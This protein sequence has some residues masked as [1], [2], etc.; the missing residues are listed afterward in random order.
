MQYLVNSARHPP[1]RVTLQNF[2]RLDNILGLAGL[3]LQVNQFGS[4]DFD[5]ILSKRLPDDILQFRD[6]FKAINHATPFGA[7]GPVFDQ[8]EQLGVRFDCAVRFD[9]HTVSVSNQRFA[10]LAD[11]LTQRFSARETYPLGR[12]SADFVD[13]LVKTHIR[14]RIEFRIAEKA[15]KI[16]LC[17]AD[18]RRRL[19]YAQAFTLDRVE[20]LVDLQGFSVTAQRHL[21]GLRVRDPV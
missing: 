3:G 18:K 14:E 7:D 1:L 4:I 21:F 2:E 9:V 11:I 17:Q 19:S 20:D 12:V 6:P 15:G 10:E 8:V 13:N 5:H 16:A